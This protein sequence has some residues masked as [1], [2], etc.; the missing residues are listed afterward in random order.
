MIKLV[1]I[2]LH[3]HV[4]QQDIG[5]NEYATYSY[6]ADAKGKLGVYLMAASLLSF[7]DAAAAG[8]DY[9]VLGIRG[10]VT[11]WTDQEW[12]TKQIPKD[13]HGDCTI[14]ECDTYQGKTY[15]ELNINS[16]ELYIPIVLL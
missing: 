16:P 14:P 11:E 6:S 7:L 2:Q 9:N 4:K 15:P 3:E 5:P 1:K 8:F 13:H 12:E 10:D